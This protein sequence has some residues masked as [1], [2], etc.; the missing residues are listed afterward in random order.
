VTQ[1]GSRLLEIV[2]SVKRVTDIVDEI[3]AIAREQANGMDQ[4]SKAI[5]QIDTVTQT[6]P[7]VA[8]SCR[9][10]WKRCPGSRASF[11]P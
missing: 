6:A 11:S 8:R 4:V 1:S 10:L 3:A 9:A 7:P 2:S 5:S